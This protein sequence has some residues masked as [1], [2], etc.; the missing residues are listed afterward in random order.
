V[1]KHEVPLD[2]KAQRTGLGK[3]RTR[4][5]DMPDLAYL[6]IA[7]AVGAIPAYF[8]GRRHEWHRWHGQRRVAISRGEARRLTRVV[9]RR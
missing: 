2:W 6:I 5:E 7:A 9:I 8:A 3:Q 1:P 4:N